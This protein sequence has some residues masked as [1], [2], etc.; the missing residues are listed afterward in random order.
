MNLT[1]EQI[2]Q[3]VQ[4]VVRHFAVPPVAAAPATVE[5][6]QAA[7]REEG[8]REG[9][10]VAGRVITHEV[11]ASTARQARVVHIEA[12]AIV[13]PSARDF[14][15]QHAIQLVRESA[16]AS[17]TVQSPQRW[18]VLVSQS[19]PSVSAALEGLASLGVACTARVAGSPAEAAA[20]AITVLCRGEVQQVVVFTSQPELVACLANRQERV[21]AAA[22]GDVAGIERIRRQLQCNLLA[23]DPAKKGV[24]ELKSLLKAFRAA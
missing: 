17:G 10:R 12:R 21:R 19:S 15:R 6:P 2:E 18:L 13:T 16:P 5:K 24:F 11:L 20:E 8:T 7:P 22:T 9:V 3:I 4:Q 1:P 23:L 14:L